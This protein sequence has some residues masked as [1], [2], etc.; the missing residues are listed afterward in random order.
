MYFNIARQYVCAEGRS[1]SHLTIVVHF[2]T[3]YIVTWGRGVVLFI[4]HLANIP[5]NKIKGS[6]FPRIKKRL[7]KLFKTNRMGIIKKKPPN[8]IKTIVKNCK[9]L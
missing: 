4:L 5:Y 9:L 3:Q 6:I 2:I 1:G 7:Q 8:E